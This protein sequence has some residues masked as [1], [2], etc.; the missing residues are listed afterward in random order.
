MIPLDAAARF[1]DHPPPPRRNTLMLRAYRLLFG[2]GCLISLA[3]VSGCLSLGTK[4]TYVQESPETKSRIESLE[5]RISALEQ[6]VLRD[7]SGK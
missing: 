3:F 2:A 6:M 5:Q 1:A 4:T 7:E